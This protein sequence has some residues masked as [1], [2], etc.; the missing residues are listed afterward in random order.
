MKRNL[1]PILGILLLAGCRHPAGPNSDDPKPPV[2]PSYSVTIGDTGG[3]GTIVAQPARAHAGATIILQVSPAEGYRLS[4][5]SLT[6]EGPGGKT[7]L[8]DPVRSFTLRGGNVTVSAKFEP[9]TQNIYSISSV[10]DSEK[11]GIIIPDPAFGPEKTVVHLSVIPNDGYQYMPGSLKAEGAAAFDELART[12]T[13]GKQNI[14]VDAKFTSIDKGNYTVRVN[15]SQYGHIIAKPDNGK[16]GTEIYLQVIPD[17]GYVL[18]TGSLGYLDIE[19]EHTVNETLR[20]IILPKSHILVYGEFEKIPDHTYSIGITNMANGRILANSQYAIQ[21]RKV[22]LQV[23]PDSGYALKEGTLVYKTSSGT[24]DISSSDLSFEMPAD[25]IMISAEFVALEKDTFSVQVG[26]F[27][28]GRI[29]AFPEYGKKDTNIYL[30]IRAEAGYQL[31]PGSLCYV[32]SFGTEHPVNEDGS[33][34]LP[35]GHVKIKAE[36]EPLS[37]NIYS[38]QAGDLTNG[39]IIALPG[40]GKEST[41]VSLWVMPDPGYYYKKGTLKYKLI[42]SNAEFQVSDESRNFK[43]NASN[44]QVSAEFVKTPNNGLTIQV[45][46]ADH[47]MIYPRQ[48]YGNPNQR[49]EMIIRPNPG[50]QLKPGSLQYRDTNNVIRKFNNNET[51]FYLS[52]EHVLVSGEFEAVKYTGNIDPSIKNGTISLTPQQA[53]IGTP[54]QLEI[55]PKNGYRLVPN[56]LKYKNIKTNKETAI[57]EKTRSFSMPP[58]DVTIMAQFEPYSP[59][60]DLKVNGRIIKGIVSGRTDYTVWIPRQE[61]KAEITFTAM[62]GVTVSP[63]SGETI[64]LNVLEKKTGVFTVTT[65]DGKV[66]T[67]YNITVIREL[68]PTREVPAGSFQRDKST[69][70]ISYISA[71]RMGERE[72]TQEEWNK[73][74]S[75]KRGKEGD[76]MPAH[77]VSWYEAVVFCNELSILEGKTPVY[78]VNNSTDPDKWGEIPDLMDNFSWNVSCKWTADGYRLPTEMEWQWAAMGADARLPERTNVAGYA[79]SFA[80]VATIGDPDDAAWHKDNSGGTIHPVGEKKPNELGFYDMSGNVTEWCWDWIYNNYQKNYNM[81]GKQTNFRG[82]DNNTGPKMRRGG[83]YLSNEEALFL[84]YRGVENGSQEIPYAVGDPRTNDEYVGLRI[85]YQN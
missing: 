46:P 41:P 44:V 47:G 68:I 72:V 16:E 19:K 65:Q 18:K 67:D 49:I 84:N 56:S 62:D 59:L 50:Y 81:G 64:S 55:I 8:K 78:M 14:K 69:D 57:N 2:G 85:L 32:D 48:D 60:G 58:E 83:S 23:Y 75:F 4:P 63:A 37:A 76:T 40:S 13:L 80:G 35:S 20:T 34:L 36:F 30:R 11:G 70:N 71:F 17:P 29:T 79:Y 27:S 15:N 33:F 82:G 3:K 5:D 74:M 10:A 9:L 51:T 28:H 21:G 22:S 52:R 43:L 31:K 66:K 77:S 12:V 25:N 54:I 1:I 38:I 7:I 73:V 42:P 6:V 45:A 26:K 53:T 24:A 39:H 61:D